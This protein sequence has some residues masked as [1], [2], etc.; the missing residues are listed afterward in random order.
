MNIFVPDII[1]ENSVK[2]QFQDKFYNWNVRLF[3]TFENKKCKHYLKLLSEA[4]N[5]RLYILFWMQA[6]NTR[7][8]QWKLTSVWAETNQFKKVCMQNVK[9][10]C[11][12]KA[13]RKC[14]ATC[15]FNLHDGRKYLMHKAEMQ[16][17]ILDNQVVYHKTLRLNCLTVNWRKEV[18]I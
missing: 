14:R 8:E 3:C 16:V 4:K 9:C 17:L 7:T 18:I 2:I 15:N 5:R 6:T 10:K 1:K 11:T 13:E 12:C